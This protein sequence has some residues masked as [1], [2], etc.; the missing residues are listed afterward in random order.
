MV[1]YIC[2]YPLKH[3]LYEYLVDLCTADDPVMW[4][5]LAL[6]SKYTV[7]TDVSTNPHAVMLTFAH[8]EP[9]LPIQTVSVSLR[10]VVLMQITAQSVDHSPL[11]FFR[12]I[13]ESVQYLSFRSE[14]YHIVCIKHSIICLLLPL[15]HIWPRSILCC[16]FRIHRSSMVHLPVLS[17]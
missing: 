10:P 13:S 6:P 9:V 14:S 11:C 3:I 16:E 7:I 12:F 2:T 17:L 5:V 4:W 15:F 1:R 8:M